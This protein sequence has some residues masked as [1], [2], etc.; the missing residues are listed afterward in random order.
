MKIKC[1]RL[2]H[3]AAIIILL[4]CKTMRSREQHLPSIL[5]HCTQKNQEPVQNND[6]SGEIRLSVCTL[7]EADVL[8]SVDYENAIKDFALVKTR[9]RTFC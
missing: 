2:L 6:G 5:A 1:P 4:C 8:R 7:H 3:R 9:K